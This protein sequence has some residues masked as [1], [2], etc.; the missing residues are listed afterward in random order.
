MTN[1]EN[2][3]ATFLRERLAEA[4]RVGS[5]SNF[6]DSKFFE[7]VLRGDAKLSLDRVEEVASTLNCNARQLFRLAAGQ[8]Y[9]E[10]AI[11]LFE[12]MLGPPLT[13]EEQMWLNAIRSANEGPVLA[14]S[15]TAKRLARALAKPYDS[16]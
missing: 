11:C 4:N 12:R 8:F 1:S 7:M 5:E 16:E 14:P 6:L 10:D 3:V 15:G 2:A 13:D 9:D